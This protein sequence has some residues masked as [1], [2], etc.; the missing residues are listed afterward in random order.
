MCREI[1]LFA[2]QNHNW[3]K[4][5]IILRNNKQLPS[6]EAVSIFST[7]TQIFIA[8]GQKPKLHLPKLH[9]LLSPKSQQPGPEGSGRLLLLSSSYAPPWK[10]TLGCQHSHGMFDSTLDSALIQWRY[11]VSRFNVYSI[12]PQSL[13]VSAQTLLTTAEIPQ[14]PP[15]CV[16]WLT[17]H[18]R[19]QRRRWKGDELISCLLP[20]HSHTQRFTE[21]A[22]QGPG[23]FWC[24]GNP[25]P[26][27][28]SATRAQAG[29]SPALQPRCSSAGLEPGLLVDFCNEKGTQ[30]EGTGKAVNEI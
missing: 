14:A 20:L 8:C 29:Q 28:P 5:V 26:L 17:S 9:L 27:I 10:W 1:L 15:G 7:Y 3:G 30:W 21:H 16:P 24:Q 4:S 25:A 19:G 18:P 6:W 13:H 23:G 11:C 22:L 2:K 12:N